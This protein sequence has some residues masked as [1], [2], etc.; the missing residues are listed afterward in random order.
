M[1]IEIIKSDRNLNLPSVQ[2][3]SAPR[4]SESDAVEHP[5]SPDAFLTNSVQP[6]GALNLLLLTRR[7]LFGTGWNALRG[8]LEAGG[9]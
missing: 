7:S 9:P 3:N 1:Q 2:G 8:A 5:E 4:N 6:R